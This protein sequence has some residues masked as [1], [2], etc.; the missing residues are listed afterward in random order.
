MQG[1]VEA[2]TEDALATG[3]PQGGPHRLT[4]QAVGLQAASRVHGV[5]HLQGKHST[6]C[7]ERGP[8]LGGSAQPLCTGKRVSQR[9]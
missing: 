4:V 5:P 2:T 7:H 3:G 1:E 8:D 9:N 6:R